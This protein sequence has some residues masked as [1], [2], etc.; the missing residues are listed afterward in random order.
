[1]R[2]MIV[3]TGLSLGLGAGFAGPAAGHPHAFIDTTVEV[4]VDDQNRATGVRIGWEYDDF[5]TLSILADLGFDTDLDGQ[6]TPE[7]TTAIQG[8]DMRWQPGVEGDSYA[9]LGR[10][11]L[12]LSYPV[13]WTTDYAGNRLKTTHL[14]Q[15]AAPIPL[16]GQRLTIRVYDP[17]YYT[18]YT[19]TAARVTGGVGCRVETYAPDPAKADQTLL[20]ALAALPADVNA[21]DS[22][23]QIG[24]SFAQE[25]RVTCEAP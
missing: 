22:Y 19:L 11:A 14:R 2:W 23:P 10:Q 8:F 1:M 18:A 5:T 17:G 20:A 15:F 24:S 3:V 6:L 13:A 12:A 4:L 9:L 7:E 25:A 16:D 21:E